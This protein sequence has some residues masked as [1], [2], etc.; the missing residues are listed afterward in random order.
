[1]LGLQSPWEQ[2]VSS[3]V[4][5]TLVPPSPWEQ[6][7]MFPERQSVPSEL[8]LMGMVLRLEVLPDQRTLWWL[9]VL[10][11]PARLPSRVL[12]RSSATTMALRD[13]EEHTSELQ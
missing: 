13:P 10:P 3:M 1:M 8:S 9:G 6:A 5:F 7:V 12:G 2:T 11:E 4:G